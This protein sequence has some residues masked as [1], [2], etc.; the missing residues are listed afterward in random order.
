V[1]ILIS[2]VIATEIISSISMCDDGN[3]DEQW[4]LV[5]AATV[6]GNRVSQPCPAV[7][8]VESMGSASRLC[9]SG[10]EWEK[11]V[12]VSMC[13]SAAFDVIK[14]NAVSHDKLE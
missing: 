3:V 13:V 12:D 10:G 1:V 6:T 2:V 5:W 4:G 8:G 14:R 9:D 7:S 11:E